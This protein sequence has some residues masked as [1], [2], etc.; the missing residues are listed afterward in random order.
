MWTLIS[1]LSKRR[2]THTA[3]TTRLPYGSNADVPELVKLTTKAL[4]LTPHDIPETAK[5]TETIKRLLSNLGTIT[6]G[7]SELRN[8]YGTGHGKVAGTRA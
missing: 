2:H 3:N 8:H 5:T 1:T 6:Q 4:E 7:I